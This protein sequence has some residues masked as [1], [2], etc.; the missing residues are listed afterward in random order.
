MN[1]NQTTK[2]PINRVALA[3]YH[4]NPKGSGSAVTFELS[5]AKDKSGGSIFA[6]FAMQKTVASNQGG[7]KTFASFDWQNKIVVKLDLYDLVAMLQVF[8]GMQEKIGVD[9]KGLFHQSKNA[10]TNIKLEHKVEPVCSYLLE[11]YKRPNDNSPT[12]RAYIFLTPAEALGLS[13]IIE[14]SLSLIA[15]GV[16]PLP[17]IY[18]QNKPSQ[19]NEKEAI[20]F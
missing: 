16:Q 6:S 9:G 7:E 2:R 13:L 5:P 11:V 1:E 10:T 15:F 3:Y 19:Y 14:N 8:R 4:A 17:N 12:Q 20:G 18:N